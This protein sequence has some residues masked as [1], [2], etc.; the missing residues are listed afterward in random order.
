[1]LPGKEAGM[2]RSL[3][4][5]TNYFSLAVC[6][7]IFLHS[8]HGLVFVRDAMRCRE[9]ERYGLSPLLLYSL[10]IPGTALRRMTFTSLERPHALYAVLHRLWGKEVEGFRGLPDA[11]LLSRQ[12]AAASPTLGDRL[13]RDG[14]ELIIAD[15]G[16]K[17]SGAALR[18]AQREAIWLGSF[19]DRSRRIDTLD[20]LDEA[21]AERHHFD[22]K[23]HM[24]KDRQRQEQ[25]AALPYRPPSAPAGGEDMD[26]SPGE[27]LGSWERDLPPVSQPRYFH[28]DNLDRKV[29]LL[30]GSGSDTLDDGIEEDEPAGDQ[31]WP[32]V[33]DS[34]M[35]ALA[36]DLVSCWPNSA[37]EIARSIDTT[38]RS[39]KWFLDGKA[40][41]DE[42][43]LSELLPVLGIEW[44]GHGRGSYE[45]SG[46][47]V[48]IAKSLSAAIRIYEELSHGGDLTFSFEVMPENGQADPSWRYLLFQSWGGP[49]SI[50]MFERGSTPADRLNGKTFINF[51][52]VRPVPSRLYRDVV[53]TAARA[54]HSARANRR[55]MRTFEE[56]HVVGS[57]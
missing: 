47:C 35:V 39:L 3:P 55:E 46:P 9:A 18:T 50:M 2:N 11:L 38:T 44:R 21:A 32:S 24:G 36:K 37:A 26:W 7:H 40:G 51:E 52:G 25:W 17:I 4:F 42:R 31:G 12:V 16:D 5:R 27:W 54:S 28:K 23:T 15:K 34:T 22:A 48:L 10:S 49:P 8:A 13:S 57:W 33:D 41:L 45:A 56:R 6:K 1:M 29:W 20:R 30:T 14:V 53:T 43:A 19:S